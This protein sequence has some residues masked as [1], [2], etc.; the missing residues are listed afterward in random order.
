MGQI[1]YVRA[2]EGKPLVML[3]ASGRSSRMFAQVM[4]LL[5]PE[6]AVY[7]LDTPGFGNSDPLPR[8]ATWCS[9]GRVTA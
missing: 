6:F 5:A 1:H 2:G 8:G 3:S 4:P 7:A 9:P